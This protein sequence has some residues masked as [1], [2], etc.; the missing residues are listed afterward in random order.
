[1]RTA[2]IAGLI[3]K[4]WDEI[5]ITGRV[6]SEEGQPRLENIAGTIGSVSK[7][8]CIKVWPRKEIYDGKLWFSPES[9][10]TVQ[11]TFSAIDD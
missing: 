3:L 6:T 10:E 2:T 9:T 5:I 8:G 4:E 7:D 11:I 1:M